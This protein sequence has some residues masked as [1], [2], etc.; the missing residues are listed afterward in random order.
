MTE[1]I[2][3]YNSCFM[4]DSQQDNVTLQNKFCTFFLL[5]YSHYQMNHCHH[6]DVLSHHVEFAQNQI[7]LLPNQ[8]QALIN[9]GGRLAKMTITSQWLTWLGNHG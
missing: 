9:L 1:C 5:I 2:D 8:N 3:P 4:R 7:F 6:Q